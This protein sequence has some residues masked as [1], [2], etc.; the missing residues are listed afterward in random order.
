VDV[1]SLTASLAATLGLD[2]DIITL[3]CGTERVPCDSRTTSGRR[4]LAG[5]VSVAF[6]VIVSSS[7]SDNLSE[8]M[9]SSDFQ[10]SLLSSLAQSNIQAVI[11]SS[12]ELLV[13]FRLTD[14]KLFGFQVRGMQLG[15]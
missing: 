3:L 12:G 2:P 4:L 6:E 7:Q 13:R 8:A 15:P 14:L 1:D 9:A 5:S 11:T 10:H